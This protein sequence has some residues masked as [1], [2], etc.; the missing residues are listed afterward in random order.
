MAKVGVEVYEVDAKKLAKTID[1]YFL[2]SDLSKDKEKA[3]NIG[4]NNFSATKLKQKYIDLIN[5]SIICSYD[6]PWHMVGIYDTIHAVDEIR[7]AV[8]VSITT[9]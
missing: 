1:E 3:F 5:S 4:Y 9:I 7:G 6:Y 8:K 2:Q